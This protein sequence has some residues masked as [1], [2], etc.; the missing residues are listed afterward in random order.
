[1]MA[2]NFEEFLKHFVKNVNCSLDN[3][4]LLLLDNHD[5]H[6]S[7]AGIDYAKEHGIIMLS[8]PPHCSHKLQPLDRSVYDPFK[9]YYNSACDAWLTVNIQAGFR[10][11]GFSLY[12]LYIVF[13]PKQNYCKKE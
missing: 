3:P 11:S 2:E 6:I 5:S 9:K 4:A 10:V 13:L 1:M 8:F 7:I 12:L